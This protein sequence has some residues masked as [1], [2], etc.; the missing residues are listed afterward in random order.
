[1]VTHAR[2]HG[3]ALVGPTAGQHAWDQPLAKWRSRLDTI[4]GA[5]VSA[6]SRLSQ[7]RLRALPVLSYLAQLRRPPPD[8]DRKERVALERFLKFPH[9]AL[10]TQVLSNLRAVGIPAPP[11]ASASCAAAFARA[12][13]QSRARPGALARLR[14]ARAEFL[15]LAALAQHSPGTPGW[16]QPSIADLW[17]L[18]IAPGDARIP[19]VADIVNEGHAGR[20]RGLRAMLTSAALRVRITTPP[21][22]ALWARVGRLLHDLGVPRPPPQEFRASVATLCWCPPALASAAIRTWTSAGSTTARQQHEPGGCPSGCAPPAV[23]DGVHM[24][25][26]RALWTAATSAIGMNTPSILE[27]LGITPTPRLQRARSQGPPIGIL[28]NA[29]AFEIYHWRPRCLAA[30][31]E[32]ACRLAE[33]LAKDV[34][35]HLAPL[36]L[37]PR[38]AQHALQP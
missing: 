10:P 17:T 13:A 6:A 20:R 7:Y 29:M 31:A 14:A 30:C 26:C 24:M 27:R 4:S 25:Q 28:M 9:N 21:D 23:G 34:A 11:P 1:M 33:S 35:R 3:S 18:A 19:D 12:A 38:A 15:P 36:R 32:D 5:A 16:D 8:L 2:H 22:E 37:R